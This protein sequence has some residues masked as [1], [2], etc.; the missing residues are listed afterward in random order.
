MAAP[1]KNVFARLGTSI[2]SQTHKCNISVALKRSHAIVSASKVDPAPFD[3]YSGLI[4]ERRPIITAEQTDLEKRYQALL[5]TIELEKSHY[6]MHELRHKADIEL[7]TRRLKED[8]DET[9]LSTLTAVDLEDQ[10]TEELSMFSQASRLTEA[11]RTGNKQTSQRYLD[12]CVYLL[13]QQ[14]FSPGSWH[15]VF[16]QCIS[17][18]GE[19]TRQTCDQILQDLS[20]EISVR[21]LGNAPST[22]HRVKYPKSSVSH[23]GPVSAKIFL[24]KVLLLTGDLTEL[25]S[26]SEY[27]DFCWVTRNEIRE[28]V[29]KTYWRAVQPVLHSH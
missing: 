24:H 28:L 15:W 21:Y 7:A 12:Q 18:D 1:I 13:V 27:G 17:V 22:F 2:L 14:S 20:S 25:T 23:E 19:S 26:G 9:E 4:I 11:D 6:C 8:V 3:L 29:T 10:W 16:P 5:N